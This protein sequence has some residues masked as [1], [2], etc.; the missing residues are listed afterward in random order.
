MHYYKFETAFEGRL[1]THTDLYPH[2]VA[3]HRARFD[4]TIQ[5][6]LSSILEQTEDLVQRPETSWA[7]TEEIVSD[8]LYCGEMTVEALFALEIPSK[9]RAFIA[10]EEGKVGV[11]GPLTLGVAT[12]G[13]LLAQAI[14]MPDAAAFPCDKGQPCPSRLPLPYGW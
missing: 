3:Y 10:S 9:I 5:S 14:M 8:I 6:L 4:Q 12:G 1:Q 2:A 13:A 7:H 11:K